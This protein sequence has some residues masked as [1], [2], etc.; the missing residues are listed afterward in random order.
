MSHFL[1]LLLHVQVVRYVCYFFF[2]DYE[3]T[4]FLV[5]MTKHHVG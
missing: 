5:A 2:G 1:L 3:I 4:Y